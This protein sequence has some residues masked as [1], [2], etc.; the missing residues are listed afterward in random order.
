MN[1]KRKL[2]GSNIFIENDLSYDDRKKQEEIFKWIKEKKEIGLT[3]K[4]GHGRIMFKNTW[5]KWEE[6]DKVEVEIENSLAK[7]S[8]HHTE[9]REAHKKNLNLE[10]TR[11]GEEEKVRKL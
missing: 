4:A 10:W 7:Q 3:V 8:K 5:F 1:R 6:R 9:G 11:N 2:V